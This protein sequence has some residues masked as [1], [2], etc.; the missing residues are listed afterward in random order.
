MGKKEKEKS[1][2]GKRW[3]AQFV[4]GGMTKEKKHHKTFLEQWREDALKYKEKK[5]IEEAEKKEKERD[6]VAHIQLYEMDINPFTKL[7]LTTA[8]FT[9]NG[10]EISAYVSVDGGTGD[11]FTIAATAN[12]DGSAEFEY[13]G[14][15]FQLSATEIKALCSVVNGDDTP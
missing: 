10:L 5:A 13:A 15:S 1:L 7:R 3:E 2:L 8:A 12:N 14:N 4:Y 6:R 11:L 9:S